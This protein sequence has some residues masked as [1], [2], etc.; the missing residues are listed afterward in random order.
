MEPNAAPGKA[1]LVEL[2]PAQEARCAGKSLT[3]TRPGLVAP[4]VMEN[5]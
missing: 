4:Q 3:V 1:W 5:R 2:R